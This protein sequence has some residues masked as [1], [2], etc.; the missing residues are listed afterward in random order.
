MWLI[1]LSQ[2]EGDNS[3]KGGIKEVM[4][5]RMWIG[6]GVVAA[7]LAVAGCATTK[8]SSS[9]L[10]NRVQVL[11]SKVQALEGSSVTSEAPVSFEQGSSGVTAATMTKKQIQEALKNA[12]YYDGK[13]DGKI[14]PKTT[15]AIKQFQKDMGLKADGIAGRNTKEKLLKYLP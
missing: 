14:G 3:A 13:V 4:M 15:A 5:N 12:G 9:S 1:R 11:E 6:I 7:A 2:V 10:E 8:S